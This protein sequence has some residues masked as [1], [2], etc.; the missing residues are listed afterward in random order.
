MR[1]SPPHRE[2][3]EAGEGEV[4]EELYRLGQRHGAREDWP[5]LRSLYI[6]IS[7]VLSPQWIPTGPCYD[8]ATSPCVY[9]FSL[10]PSPPPHLS[11]YLCALYIK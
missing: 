9:S 6:I 10:S 5:F 3:H 1:R 4:K 7:K 11:L 2:K 8:R